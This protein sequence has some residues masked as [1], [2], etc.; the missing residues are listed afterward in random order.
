MTSA[1]SYVLSETMGI[2]VDFSKTLGQTITESRSPR[3]PEGLDEGKFDAVIEKVEKAITDIHRPISHSGTAT[4]AIIGVSSG[5]RIVHPLGPT[6]SSE[7]FDYLNTE[8]RGDRRHSYVGKVSSYNTNTYK[9]RVYVEDE[10]RPVPMT[11]AEDV[12]SR[13]YVRKVVD[14]LAANAMDRFDAGAE[15]EFEA[16]E[17]HSKSGR[18]KRYYVVDIDL[19][20]KPR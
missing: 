16:Y 5:G 19:G 9:G 18:L 14:S 15:I 6:L 3:V 12:Q 7:T 4:S 13:R 11:L 1:Y 17:S 20:T 8:I 10:G 2:S